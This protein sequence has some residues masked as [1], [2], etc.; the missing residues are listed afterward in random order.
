MSGALPPLP[1]RSFIPP[2]V[3]VDSTLGASPP[4]AR[5]NNSAA[6]AENGYTVDEPTMLMSAAVA[7]I[8]ATSQAAVKCLRDLR[9]FIVFSFRRIRIKS[10]H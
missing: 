7:G 10:R 4:P 5:A 6:A 2:P 9:V 3:P 1:Q 8:V